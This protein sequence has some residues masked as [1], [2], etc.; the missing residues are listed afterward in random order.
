MNCGGESIIIT[1]GV[2]VNSN[3]SYIHNT[4]LS[5][6]MHTES[7]TAL[8]SYPAEFD[9]I[10]TISCTDTSKMSISKWG[11]VVYEYKERLTYPFESTFKAPLSIGCDNNTLAI[12]TSIHMYVVNK[13][14]CLETFPSCTP[15]PEYTCTR[16]CPV[17][18]YWNGIDFSVYFNKCRIGLSYLIIVYSK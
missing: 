7:T 12:N 6:T 13:S 4:S 10:I 16:L 18:Y 9:P 15:D 14:V 8:D 11:K 5:V 1:T 2:S 3:C 17:D